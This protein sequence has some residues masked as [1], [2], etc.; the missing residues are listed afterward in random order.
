[1]TWPTG[2]RRLALAAAGVPLAAAVTV[3]MLAAPSL[4]APRQVKTATVLQ[5]DHVYHTLA[6]GLRVRKNPSTSAKVIHVLGARGSKVTVS[7][8]ALGTAVFGDHVWYR[9]VKPAKGKG[10][11]VAGFY[12]STGRDPAAGVPECTVAMRTFRTTVAHLKVRQTPSTTEK[13]VHVLGKA[14]TRVSVNCW[15]HGSNVFGDH[16]WY[17]IVTPHKGY[18]AGFYLNTGRDPAP[19]IAHC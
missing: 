11:F 2:I 13:I 4:A 3:T 9:L 17:H 19:G 12:L 1:M 14:G 6:T 16:I 5:A 7:C 10:G 8:W 15:R 18:V